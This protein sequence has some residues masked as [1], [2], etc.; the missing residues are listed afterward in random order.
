MGS[1][2]IDLTGKRFGRW[3]VL[4]RTMDRGGYRYWYCECG[5]GSIGIIEGSSLR[6]G[7]S[8]SCGCHQKE[9]ASHFN[10]T[11][12]E[13]K[14]KLYDVLQGIKSRCNDKTNTHY[15]AKGISV[16]S[17]WNDFLAFKSWAHITGYKVGLEIDRID[18]NG[19]YEPNN[20]R[21]ATPKEN[22]RNKG[23]NVLLTLNGITKCASAW[24]EETG[25]KYHTILARK[26]R[27]WSDEKTLTTLTGNN[28]GKK[29]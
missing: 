24:S 15:G 17:E 22:G 16:C 25:I 8:L 5:C 21:W 26:M 18:S 3:V 19:D 6:R 23:N 2:L 4:A 13:S 10:S 28:A 20:C 1:T 27:G 14:T 11:H 9:V 29:L 12:G 7:A